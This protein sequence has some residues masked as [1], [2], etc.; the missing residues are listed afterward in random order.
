MAIVSKVKR[1]IRVFPRRTSYTPDDPYVF[2]G[3]PIM[4]ELLPPHDEIHIT[5]TFTW[6]MDYCEKLKSDWE[7]QT[8]EEVKL[9]GPAYLSSAENFTPGLYVKDGIIFT[10]RGCNNYCKWCGVRKIEGLL[11][12]LPVYPGNIIQDNNFLQTSR[13]HKEDVF[14]MLKQQRKIEFKG[15]LE[16]DLIDNHFIAGLQSIGV[17]KIKSLWL[18]CDTDS[19]LPR[20]KKAVEKLHKAGFNQNKIYCYSL[21]GHNMEKEEIRNR[22][23]FNAGAL[24]FSQLERDFTR[25]KA[26]YS[27][28]WNHFERVWQRPAAM[29]AHM[30]TVVS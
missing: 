11:K 12:E 19:Q 24:P 7:W 25:Q 15:G 28:E 4:T 22:E 23:I 3:E 10:S 20:F 13:K 5:C 14:E 1:I 26:Q 30:K 18:A 16:T 29:K 27:K 6:D 17:K 8:N 9:G 2:I 21:I